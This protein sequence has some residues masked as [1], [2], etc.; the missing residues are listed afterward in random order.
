MSG[1]DVRAVFGI[2]L[3]V[4]QA[5]LIAPLVVRAVRA[6]SARG[7][8][9]AGEAI[10]AVAGLGWAVFGW[11]TG[12]RTLIASGCLAT[13][14]SGALIVLCARYTP[15]R[16]RIRS[17][18]LAA[19]VAAGLIAS[20]AAAGSAGLNVALSAF[21]VVQFIPQIVTAF[22]Q[23]THRRPSTALSVTGTALRGVYTGGWAVW[24]GAWFVWGFPPGEIIW[25]LTA[26]G[27]AGV[28]AFAFQA[29]VAHAGTVL[30]WETG[31]RRSA[32]G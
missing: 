21:G 8:A 5:A 13:L 18:I 19:V 16:V 32:A 12:S 22:S 30:H 2:V 17:A 11:M 9:L 3:L 28:V 6:R 10:W 1:E 24:A 20:T 31:T 7:I 14:G 26:W 25:P 4:T 15:R 23:L 27:L 29:A